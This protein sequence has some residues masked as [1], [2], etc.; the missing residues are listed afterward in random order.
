MLGR[1]WQIYLLKEKELQSNTRGRFKA[2][3]G[4]VTLCEGCVKPAVDAGLDS[5]AL[6]VT[7]P[8]TQMYRTC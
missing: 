1:I 2:E 7:P 8:E 6:A 3:K 4:G 5:A